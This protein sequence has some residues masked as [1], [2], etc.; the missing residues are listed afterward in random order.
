MIVS[1]FLMSLVKIIDE[2]LSN[3]IN[4]KFSKLLRIAEFW[5]I[6][7]KDWNFFKFE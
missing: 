6:H 7:D 5:S 3:L 2:N 1:E 4:Q